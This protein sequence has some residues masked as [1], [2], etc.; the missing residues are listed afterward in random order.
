[1]RKQELLM[2]SE[3][4][5]DR[6]KVLNEVQQGHVTQKEA[7][8]QLQVSD[9]W[10]RSLLSRVQEEGDGGVVH[11][12]R[13]RPSNRRIAARVKRQAVKLVK[14]H[15]ADFGP[16]LAAEYLARSIVDPSF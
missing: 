4:D 15:Y 7:G 10:I 3:K 13:G 12:L 1:M 2:L 5:R 11:Q 6:L 8:E 14:A 16:T 9:R